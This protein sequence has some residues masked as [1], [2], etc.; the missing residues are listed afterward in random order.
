MPRVETGWTVVPVMAATR[1]GAYELLAMTALEP[2]RS[3]VAA[4]LTQTKARTLSSG[5][6]HLTPIIQ[7]GWSLDITL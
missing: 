5:I 3:S 6:V 1:Q 2:Q 7:P 4:T